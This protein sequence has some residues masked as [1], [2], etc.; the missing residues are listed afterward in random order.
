VNK[1]ISFHKDA[2][3]K[4]YLHLHPTDL[5]FLN[6]QL[7]CQLHKMWV[8]SLRSVNILQFAIFEFTEGLEMDRV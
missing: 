2:R 7:L 1:S 4:R 8:T 3:Q 5:D 6:P